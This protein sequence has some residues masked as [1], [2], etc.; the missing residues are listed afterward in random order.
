[1]N[2]LIFNA[3]DILESLLTE[4][5]IIQTKHGVFYVRGIHPTMIQEMQ[6]GP[7]QRL[8]DRFMTLSKCLFEE[9]EKLTIPTKI[10][11]FIKECLSL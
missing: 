7:I 4:G 11:N 8:Q 10:S 6:G 2:Y 5:D 9:E 3:M 1:M